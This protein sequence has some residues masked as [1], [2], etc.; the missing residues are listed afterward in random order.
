MYLMV[1]SFAAEVATATTPTPPTP[2]QQ[3]AT[4]SIFLDVQPG[5]AQVFVDGYFVGA[6]DDINAGRRSLVLESGPHRIDVNA[7]GY[8][9]VSF[10]V[11]I[12]PNQSITYRQALKPIAPTPPPPQLPAAASAPM[13]FYL[14]PGCYLGNVPPK[15]AH[16][17]ATCDLGRTV[18]FKY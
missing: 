7:P 5:T 8:E 14:I 16:L 4:G 18:T 15:D 2:P 17:P 6:P 12:V 3:P 13:T 1:P 9:P 10:D 11:N